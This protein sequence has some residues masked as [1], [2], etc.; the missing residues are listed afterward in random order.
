V[1]TT[2]DRY[3]VIAIMIAG[4]VGAASY[5]VGYHDGDVHGVKMAHAEQDARVAD[6]DKAMQRV[7][8][9]RWARYMA[10]SQ[11]CPDEK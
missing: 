10:E 8:I 9:C 7:G 11:L 2:R 6:I 3:V 4:M 1:N 5:M